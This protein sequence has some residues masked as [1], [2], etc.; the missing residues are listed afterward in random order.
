VSRD[1]GVPLPKPQVEIERRSGGCKLGDL[2]KL[3]IGGPVSSDPGEMD[4]D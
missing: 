2:A 4:L 3:E 1:Q